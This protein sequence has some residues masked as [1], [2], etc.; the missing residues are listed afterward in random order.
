MKRAILV[1]AGTVTGLAAVL[2]LNPDGA[3]PASSTDTIAGD[4][5]AVTTP[6]PEDTEGTTSDPSSSDT[7]DSDSASSDAASSDSGSQDSS[8]LPSSGDS[9]SG[10]SSSDS[11]SSDSSSADSAAG[12]ASGSE[13]GSGTYKGEAV[14]VRNFGVMQVEITT[15]NGKVTD[16]TSLQVPDWDRKSEMI[17]S[18]AVPQLTA[19]ALKSQSADV[20]YIS[21]A[22]F[23]SRAFAQSLQSALT[24]AGL[25]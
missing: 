16:I 7:S 15:A 2:M 22:T 1:G 14:Q 25:A 13:A 10:G 18:Y 20:S 11:S 19:S 9:S 6:A 3:A 12:A 4:Q 17:N 5:G 21:G 24:K 8:T 23:T